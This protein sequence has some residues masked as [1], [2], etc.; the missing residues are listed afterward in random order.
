MHMALTLNTGEHDIHT[1]IKT[2]LCSRAEGDTTVKH[3]QYKPH[4]EAITAETIALLLL[5]LETSEYKKAADTAGEEESTEIIE[6]LWNNS[7]SI[8]DDEM[9]SQ[10]PPLAAK[11]SAPQETAPLFFTQNANKIL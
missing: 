5:A 1:Q 9:Q 6:N 4:H 2:M 10:T 8:K 7:I 11:K 3:N